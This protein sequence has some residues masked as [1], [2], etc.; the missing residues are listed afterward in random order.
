MSF[1]L[2]LTQEEQQTLILKLDEG[3]PL[4]A[5]EKMYVLLQTGFGLIPVEK[6]GVNR[7]HAFANRIRAERKLRSNPR[8]TQGVPY[9][10]RKQRV[11]L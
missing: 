2:G 1:R 4:S 7:L 11:P 3:L 9:R 10:R 8:N 6:R 5:K